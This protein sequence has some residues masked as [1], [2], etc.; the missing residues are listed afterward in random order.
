M[1]PAL[2]VPP[3]P[4]YPPPRHESVRATGG[5]RVPGAGPQ[6]SRGMGSSWDL[7]SRARARRRAP[8]FKTL[9]KV[10]R[11]SKLLPPLLPFLLLTLHASWRK[12]DTSL[13]ENALLVVVIHSLKLYYLVSHLYVSLSFSLKHNLQDGTQGVLASIVYPALRCLVNS[14]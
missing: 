4:P 5:E 7:P 6:Q 2:P 3:I 8:L 1:P 9:L 13:K 14:C 10:V 11:A 12:E